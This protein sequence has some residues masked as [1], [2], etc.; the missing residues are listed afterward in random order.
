[1]EGLLKEACAQVTQEDWSKVVQ[2]TKKI[3]MDDFE[4]D[5]HFDN[6]MDNQ[7]VIN[8]ND[9]DDEDDDTSTSSE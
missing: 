4:R 9:D 5:V 3:I 6:V 1:M 8:L 2:K 7:L